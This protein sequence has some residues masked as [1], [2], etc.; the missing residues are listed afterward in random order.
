MMI[1]G[2]HKQHVHN[3]YG[4]ETDSS[5]NVKDTDKDTDKEESNHSIA[6]SFDKIF[7]GE[8]RQRVGLQ[9][10]QYYYGIGF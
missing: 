7:I 3:S 6:R 5:L 1:S 8:S 10:R 9:H 2:E 4:K